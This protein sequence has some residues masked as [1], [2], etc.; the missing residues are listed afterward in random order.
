VGTPEPGTLEAILMEHS[1][2]ARFVQ[3]HYGERLPPSL[4]AEM[5]TRTASPKNGSYFPLT[6]QSFTDF[7][8]FCLLD[9]TTYSRGAP[10]LPA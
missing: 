9:S 3:T 10:P 8:W 5:P 6:A 7:D 4:I 1:G 2:P